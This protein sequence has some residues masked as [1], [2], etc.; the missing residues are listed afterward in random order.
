ML[1]FRTCEYA[2]KCAKIKFLHRMTLITRH[3]NDEQCLS[4]NI[5]YMSILNV[6]QS[7]KMAEICLLTDQPNGVK[8]ELTLLF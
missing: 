2:G 1:V 6:D 7:D 3:K 4:Y 8:S 5:Y